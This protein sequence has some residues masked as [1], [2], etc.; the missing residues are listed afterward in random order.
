MTWSPGAPGYSR[1][2]IVLAVGLQCKAHA[3]RVR[4]AVAWMGAPG[5]A[6]GNSRGGHLACDFESDPETT[7]VFDFN[8]LDTMA[9][10]DPS[11]FS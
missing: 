10:F 1:D 6:T 4:D 9:P 7:A 2:E 11:S 8:F 3:F 5:K